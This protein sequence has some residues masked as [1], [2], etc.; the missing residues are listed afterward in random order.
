MQWIR[1][2]RKKITAHRSQ[3]LETRNW[4][5]KF[6]STQSHEQKAERWA[7]KENRNRKRQRGRQRGRRRK[8]G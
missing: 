1:R 2:K 3:K 7:I 4:K 5:T 6:R 8:E